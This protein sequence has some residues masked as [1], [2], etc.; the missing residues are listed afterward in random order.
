MSAPGCTMT[1]ELTR[2]E[3]IQCGKKVK[4][5]RLRSVASIYGVYRD[6]SRPAKLLGS[7]TFIQHCEDIFVLTAIHVVEDYRK[8]EHVFHDVGGNGEQMFP[9][10]EGWHGWEQKDGDLALWGCYREIID[11]SNIQPIQVVEP[12]GVTGVCDNAFFI[13]SGYPGSQAFSLPIV[14]EYRTTLHTVMGKFASLSNIPG[15]CFAFDCANDIKYFGMSGAAVWN[16]N[17]HK[18]TDFSKWIPEMSTFAGVTIQWDNKKG[19]I[20]A[21]QAEV[22]KKFLSSSIK[23]LRKQWEQG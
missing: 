23:Q 14:R 4:E 6:K 17:L 13:T 5:L 20:L 22:V 12:F 18:C 2:N 8:F 1:F 19:Y 15:H 10:R 7:G 9:F 11:D 21:T 16:L 3:L